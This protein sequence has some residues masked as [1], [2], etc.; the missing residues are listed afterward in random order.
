[1]ATYDLRKDT[2]D[3]CINSIIDQLDDLV[4]INN[5]EEERDRTDNAKFF[6]LDRIRQ[7]VYFFTLDDDLIYP[8]D[9]VS[10]TIEA[11]EEFECI[12]TYHGRKLN[13]VGL[14]YYKGHQ[15]FTCLGKVD[16]AVEL[17]VCGTGVTA[18]RTDYFHP[19]GLANCPLHRMSDLIFS[20]EAA[21]Q[22]KTIGVIPHE[23]GW[24]THIPNKETIY[25]NEVVTGTP[26]Q[27]HL[28][29]QIF[30]LRNK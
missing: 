6:L 19:R 15:Q 5:S 9:Y 29:D 8:P 2:R 26:I 21:R 7:P 30:I 10:K 4:I 25:E 13:G 12:V 1:M 14:N 11:I 27:N 3:K 20:L 24:I 16:K 23:A 22:K 18:F 17:D 28:A